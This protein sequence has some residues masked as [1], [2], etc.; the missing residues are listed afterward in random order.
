[1]GQNRL[2]IGVWV[3]VKANR[4]H[5]YYLDTSGLRGPTVW[6]STYTFVQV[7]RRLPRFK[8]MNKVTFN[9]LKNGKRRENV[10]TR[11]RKWLV[12]GLVGWLVV[13]VVVKPL[14]AMLY[15]IILIIVVIINLLL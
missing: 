15:N 14:I 4:Y 7:D 5:R 13:V 11:C 10:A 8:K 3:Q 6:V 1:M 9:T 2:F 12:G